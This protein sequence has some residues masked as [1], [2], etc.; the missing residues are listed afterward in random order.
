MVTRYADGTCIPSGLSNSEWAA[1]TAGVCATPPTGNASVYGLLYT[2]YAVRNTSHGG[3][4]V[5]AGWR[6][7]TDEDWQALEIYLG[8]TTTDLT[9]SDWREASASVGRKLKSKTADWQA[10]PVGTA[11][12]DT[13]GLNYPLN[14][15][16]VALDV[17]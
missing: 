12:T 5:P 2:G 13:V 10:G 15:C 8:M 7:A 1:D 11:G 14:G 4:A 17:C 6:I 3:I 16:R 9:L